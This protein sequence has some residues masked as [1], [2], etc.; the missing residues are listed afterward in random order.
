MR[1]Q[2]RGATHG[3]TDNETFYVLYTLDRS[4]L[5]CYSIMSNDASDISGTV[6][7]DS[8]TRHDHS[9]HEKYQEKV[10]HL[11]DQR[12]SDVERR[13]MHGFQWHL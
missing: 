3:S 9:E 12:K 8:P 6:N 1:F 11:P 10:K 5:K 7:T 4:H 2:F 13:F